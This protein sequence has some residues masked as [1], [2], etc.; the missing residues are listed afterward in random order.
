MAAFLQV[1]SRFLRS[2]LVCWRSVYVLSRLSGMLGSDT[3]LPL[4]MHSYL[5][6]HKL[7]SVRDVGA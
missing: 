6:F 1:L 5:Q 7:H 4:C 3:W 2:C